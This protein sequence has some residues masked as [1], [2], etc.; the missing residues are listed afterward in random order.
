MNE[1]N[2]PTR[3]KLKVVIKGQDN[4]VFKSKDLQYLFGKQ[5]EY[6]K[7]YTPKQVEFF[8]VSSN[9]NK[10]KKP[11]YK[12]FSNFQEDWDNVA[13]GIN[14]EGTYYLM[15]TDTEKVIRLKEING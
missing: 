13:Y 11:R 6:I 5:D 14:S 15:N 8:F 12:T 3:H 7:L 2:F 1:I 10:I 9:V 4:K